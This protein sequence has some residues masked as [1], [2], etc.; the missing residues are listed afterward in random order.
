MSEIFS[1]PIGIL[2]N[3]ITPKENKILTQ[4][5]KKLKYH[6]HHLLNG[7]GFG[8][9]NYVENNNFLDKNIIK[10]IEK[11]SNLYGKSIHLKKLKM[12]RYWSII[13]NKKTNL[14]SHLHCD[15]IVSGCL[16]LNVNQNSNKLV[17]ENPNQNTFYFSKIKYTKYQEIHVVYPKINQLVLFPSWLKHGSGGQ[18]NQHND[19]ISVSFNL[20]HD[21]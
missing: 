19:R 2:E 7:D 20:I 21:I 18:D 12:D 8:T 15:S 10:R 9:Y 3:F 17:F 14:L 1:I 6:S 4:R 16:Y 13:Q 5:I 11:V